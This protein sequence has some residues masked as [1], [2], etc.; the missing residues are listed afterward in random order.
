[1]A[2]NATIDA[3]DRLISATRSFQK[4]NLEIASELLKCS[5]NAITAMN[6]DTTSVELKA[7]IGGIISKMSQIDEKAG[8]LKKDL[9]DTRN[10][11][12]E[13]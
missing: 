11:L 5:E 9:E 1:M 4:R 3:Y 2:Q 6:G 12:M 7:V 8:A 10:K 13:I